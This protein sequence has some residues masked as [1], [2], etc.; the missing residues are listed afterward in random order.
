MFLHYGIHLT[1]RSNSIYHRIR[2]LN[3]SIF[4]KW[5]IIIWAL[6]NSPPIHSFHYGHLWLR[7]LAQLRRKARWR[8][9]KLMMV[10]M[11]VLNRID[12]WCPKYYT[13]NFDYDYYL[14]DCK[15]NKFT[16]SPRTPEK[17]FYQFFRRLEMLERNW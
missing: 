8:K 1:M 6:I 16:I 4:R 14:S 12:K 5:S 11:R 10:L 13:S 3:K 2:P 7:Y 17:Y 9:W 15:P